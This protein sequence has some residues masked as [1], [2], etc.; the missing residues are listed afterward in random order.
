[1]IVSSYEFLPSDKRYFLRFGKDPASKT[2]LSDQPDVIKILRNK[3]QHVEDNSTFYNLQFNKFQDRLK[4]IEEKVAASSGS[5]ISSRQGVAFD[6]DEEDWKE[7]YYEE[8]EKKESLENELDFAR[9]ALEEAET[10]L[11]ELEEDFRNRAKLQSDHESRLSEIQ[12]LQGNSID[13]QKRLEGSMAREKELEQLL[14]SEITIREKYA[15]LQQQYA[16]MLSEMDDLKRRLS[17]TE[18]IGDD[19]QKARNEQRQLESKL[20]M[21][22]DENLK[23]KEECARLKR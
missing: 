12:S 7:L 21:C 4:V 16:E 9:Q 2:A 23:L 5:L 14:L 17:E 18:N 20:L 19:Y 1:M 11:K 10:K 8:N 3:V 22:R 6:E 13:L 15:L